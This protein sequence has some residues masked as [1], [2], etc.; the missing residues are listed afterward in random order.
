M[1]PARVREALASDTVVR[2]Y[3]PASEVVAEVSGR[4]YLHSGPPLEGPD[5]WP[6]ALTG[7]VVA[8]LLLEGEADTAEAALAMVRRGEVTVSPCQDTNVAGPLVGLVTPRMPMV[9][10]ERGD[11]RVF[12]SPMHEGDH[13]GARTGVFDAD[14]VSRLRHVAEVVAPLLDRAVQG[15]EVPVRPVE[16]QQQ[17]L[18]RGD[19]CHNRNVAG[20]A[21]YLV[22]L[23]PALVRLATREAEEV[24]A[25]F[26]AT[27]HHLLSL[28]AAHARACLDAIA[29]AGPDT[30]GVVTAVGMNGRDFGIK[31]GGSDRWFVAPAPTGPVVDLGLGDVTT[32]G[33]GQG[34]SPTIEST[35]LG[36]FSLSSAPA[37]AAQLG[38]DNA[39]AVSL[40]E[41]MRTVAASS[42]PHYRLPNQ[43]FRPAPAGIDAVAVSSCGTAPATTMGFLSRELGV[44]RVGAGVVRMPLA[45]F[46]D[47]AAAISSG[48]GG[49]A[50]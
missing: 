35:G 33:A 13:G 23:L 18:E 38:H 39:A 27:S 28:S 4:H 43:D 24:V 12:C 2:G 14:A 3:R 32:A 21:A 10:L 30:A 37:L 50:R 5:S 1:N 36:A 31:V 40:V 22:R 46:R 7:G 8:G 11:G 17:A 20:T 25:Y 41:E 19:E 26:G 9:V 47:A 6:A 29:G 42:S 48:A 34:D 16:V 15:L 44:G 49:A 45:P